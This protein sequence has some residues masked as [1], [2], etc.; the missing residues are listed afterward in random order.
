MI[1]VPIP[2]IA[3]NVLAAAIMWLVLL[4]IGARVRSWCR[5]PV[6]GTLRWSTD[7]AL[8]AWLTSMVILAAGLVGLVGRLP[9]VAIVAA[10]ACV[11]RWRVRR[12]ILPLAAAAVGGLIYLPVALGP[13]FFYDALVYHLGLPWQALIEG[14]WKPHPENLF[15]TF[16]P[17]SQMLS[18]PAM[19]LGLLRVP[20]LLHWLAWVTAATAVYGLA[21]RF[22]ASGPIAGLATA[23]ALVL[24]VTPLV[25]GFPA[26]EGWLLVALLAAVTLAI[27]PCRPGSAA[28]AGLLA[29]VATAARLQGIP[30]SL[31]VVL[32]VGIQ[33][34]GR[35]RI[36]GVTA[37][38]W[39]IGASPWWFKNLVLLGD[40]TAPV[41]WR[42]EGMETLWRDSHSLLKRGASVFESLV[43]VP[44]RLAPELVWLLPLL[45]V[46][47]SA[48]LFSHRRVVLVGLVLFGLAVWPATG[49]L[50]RFLAPTA[51]LLLALAATAG[52]GDRVRRLAAAAAISWCI[53]V[54]A[55]RGAQWLDRI[56]VHHLVTLDLEA[57]VALVSPNTPMGA[58][59]ESED[60][61]ADARVLFVAEPRSLAFPR[62]FITP[63]QHDVQPLRSLIETSE[64]PDR[65]ST[66]LRRRG[67]THLLINW[68]ELGRLGDAYPV[69]PWRTPM[70]QRRWSEFLRSLGPPVVH[71][72]GVQ[73]YQLPH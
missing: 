25:P 7:L 41:F 2:L 8:G 64:N 45:L 53:V 12:P 30:W 38:C 52:G 27:G 73:I 66:E 16:P 29:G 70:G 14:G 62:R 36:L 24:P 17:L 21:R 61:A 18:M 50:P 28:L 4:A 15:S 9:L 3:A 22:G 39:L 23:A 44:G 47:L 31:L 42:R 48:V 67:F 35:L 13:P 1:K 26:A 49:G 43:S 60:L 54:G 56:G 40:P 57:A 63:S 46:G 20:A 68:N 69:A 58:F 65:I 55:T 6:G 11:G 37:G 72:S 5:F 34:R 19:A 59:T 51:C 10:L 71:N 32:L 33:C